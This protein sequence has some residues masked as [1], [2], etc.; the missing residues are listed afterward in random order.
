MFGTKRRALEERVKKLE[1]ATKVMVQ[2]RVYEA[3]VA[4]KC[5]DSLLMLDTAEREDLMGHDCD[6]VVCELKRCHPAL[7]PKGKP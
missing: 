3:L 7:F 5:F 6:F 4:T 2:Q 1:K